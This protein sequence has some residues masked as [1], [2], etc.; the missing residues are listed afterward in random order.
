MRRLVALLMI[1]GFLFTES[2]LIVAPILD[3][4][5]I[6]AEHMSQADMTLK[7]GGNQGTWCAAVGGATIGA[8]FFNPAL[9]LGFGVVFMA[10][11]LSGDH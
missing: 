2:S 3:R 5:A 11:C 8:A 10:T 7:I 9:A 4:E 6:R 1:T